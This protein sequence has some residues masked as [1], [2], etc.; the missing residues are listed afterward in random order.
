[1]IV[2]TDN[3]IVRLEDVHLSFGQTQV[4]KGIDLTVNKGDA[5]SI[6]GPSGSGKSTILRCINALVTAQSGQI[7]V[8][9]TRVDQLTKESERIALRKRV[10]IVFQQYNLFPH[11]TVLDN[12]MLAPTRILGTA[13]REAE[14]IARELLD[15]V[16]LGEKADAYPGQLSGGQQQ[17]VAIARALAMKPDLVL[18]DEVTSALD[19]ETVGEVLWVIR[20]LI[21]EGM[22]SILVTHEMRF[23]EEISDTVVFTENGRIVGQGSPEQI[24]HKSDNP[25]IRQFVGG[26][27][28]RGTVREGEGI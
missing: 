27:S 24:F 18:F 6:I 14:K 19:P 1:M 4:L 21:R 3:A 7:T 15:K 8:A 10:G 26:L 22:T 13:R 28:S 23:A 12:I 25:R 5:V 17:R 2:N 11:L 9:G 20:D 16:R